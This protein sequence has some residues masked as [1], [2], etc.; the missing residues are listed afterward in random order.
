MYTPKFQPQLGRGV[1]VPG[2]TRGSRDCGPRSWQM[3]IDFLT[4]GRKRPGVWDLRRRGNV[5]GPVPTSVWDAKLAVESFDS[6]RGLTPLRYYIRRDIESVR[7]AVHNGKYVH[8]CVDYETMNKLMTR[9]GDP[10]FKGGHSIGVLGERKL[11][12]TVQWRI[13]DPL[14]DA[15]R[16]EIPQGPRWVKRWK[17]IRAM[18]DFALGEGRCYAGVFGGGR[19]R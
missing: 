14:D 17:V 7:R 19:K 9:T 1:P 8:V 15:R 4:K 11:G 3:G 16:A 5:T 10:N 12:G 2:R 13:F 6:I 18:E